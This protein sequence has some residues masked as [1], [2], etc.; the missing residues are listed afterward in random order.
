[1]CRREQGEIK[2][3]DNKI[4]EIEDKMNKLESKIEALFILIRSTLFNS[5][6]KSILI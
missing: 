3:I 6:P 5:S 2:K 4:E 1:M